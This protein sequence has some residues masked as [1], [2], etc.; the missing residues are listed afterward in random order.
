MIELMRVLLIR[1][2]SARVPARTLQAAN[3]DGFTPM[4]YL[5]P[6]VKSKI[7]NMLSV[8]A[9]EENRIHYKAKS[10][11]IFKKTHPDWSFTLTETSMIVKV[12]ARSDGPP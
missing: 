10:G 7:A 11:I 1:S 8:T 12:Q 5:S 6:P 4:D 9:E 2:D 3:F